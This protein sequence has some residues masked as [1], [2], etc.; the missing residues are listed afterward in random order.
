MT[1]TAPAD[2]TVVS[3]PQ[4]DVIGQAPPEAVISVNDSVVVVGP[5]GHFSATVPLQDGPNELEILVSDADGNQ[6]S[7]RLIVTYVPPG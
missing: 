6:A 7:T 5:S 3:V 1:I 4:V 2:E